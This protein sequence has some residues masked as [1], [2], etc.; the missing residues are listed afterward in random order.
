M[1]QGVSV[2]GV[3]VPGVHVRGGGGGYVLEPSGTYALSLH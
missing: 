1:S 2:R 3:I